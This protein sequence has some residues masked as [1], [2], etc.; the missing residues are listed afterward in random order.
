[1]QDWAAGESKPGGPSTLGL[2]LLT[3]LDERQRTEALVARL[4]LL[5]PLFSN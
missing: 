3:H 2:N 5:A 1:M 4:Q